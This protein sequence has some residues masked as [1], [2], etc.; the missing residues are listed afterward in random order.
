LK[1]RRLEKLLRLLVKFRKY[2]RIYNVTVYLIDGVLCSPD[3][4]V[5]IVF[6][7]GTETLNFKGQLN[8]VAAFLVISHLHV[9]ETGC[10]PGELTR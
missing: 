8:T 7:G 6:N 4:A 5:F 10:A 2:P 9:V 3:S 1:L